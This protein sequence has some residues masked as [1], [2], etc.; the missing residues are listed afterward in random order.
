MSKPPIETIGSDDCVVFGDDG[1][2]YHPHE[3]EFVQVV[4]GMTV[5]QYEQIT[6]MGDL[7][8]RLSAVKG[9]PDEE[10]QVKAIIRERFDSLIEALSGKVIA[11]NWTDDAGRPIVPFNATLP[12]D[13]PR[14]PG[15]PY[16]VLDGTAAPFRRL[17]SRELYWL[18]SAAEG[19]TPGEEKKDSKALPTTSS[20]S[21]R[22]RTRTR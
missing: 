3:G 13:H 19:E 11:W 6:T 18:L 1:T 5:E 4:S 8:T 10:E 12:D 22:R 2:A 16:A 20:G 7:G 9:D 14:F 17:R 15:R 21:A